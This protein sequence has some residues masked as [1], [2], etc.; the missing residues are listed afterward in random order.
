MLIPLT[1]YAVDP[2]AELFEAA[3]RGDTATVRALIA[4]GADVDAK[5][6]EGWTA[7]Q[8]DKEGGLTKIVKLLKEAGAREPSLFKGHRPL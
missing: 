6:H 2:N 1:A 3:R 5:D 4:K 8:M 7:L